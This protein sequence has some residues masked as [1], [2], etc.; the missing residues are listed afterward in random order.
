MTNRV[1]PVIMAGGKGTRLW[2]L[3]RSSAPKQFIRFTGEQT[4]FQ[5]TLLRVSD[6]RVYEQPIIITHE[7]FRFLAAEQAREL[8]LPISAI[9]LEPLGR[10]TA[11]AV[12]AAASYVVAK[13]GKDAL[14]QVLASDHEI[15]A[16]DSYF[17]SISTAREVAL[18]GKLV[19]FGVLPTEAATG[20]GYIEIGEKLNAG[21][22]AVKRFVEKPAL[23][24]AENMFANGG[25]VWN[26]GIFM[27]KIETILSEFER[28]APE[29]LE[30][31]RSAVE[32][33]SVDLDFVRLQEAAFAVSDNIS[34]D[35]AIMERTANAVVIPASF[36]W[37]DLGSW[38]AV[39][40]L[41]ARDGTGNVAL[42]NTTLIDTRDSLVMSTTSH[43]AVQGLDGVAVIASEDAVYVGRLSDSQNV[44]EIVKRLASAKSTVG[45]TETHPS[46]F[47][48]R[49]MPDPSQ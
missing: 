41:G 11:P 43:L 3:S 32:Q 14:I 1:I 46:H 19:M 33:S 38:D 30:A 24:D 28:H 36:T 35:Y 37:S 40:K 7:D 39:W 29:V 4:L 20:Y 27:F 6:E 12:A 17:S 5:S 45:L 2:P 22:H 15:A 16:D 23:A 26:S 44:G 49:I 25:Y 21:S 34:I 48:A 42:G 9:L 13:F 8:E 47:V 10:N 18:S 31:A